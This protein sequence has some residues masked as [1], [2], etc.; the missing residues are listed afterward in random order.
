[1][2]I[3]V[4]YVGGDKYSSFF[5]WKVSLADELRGSCIRAVPVRLGTRVLPLMMHCL[6][7]IEMKR[8]MIFLS[9]GTSYVVNIGKQGLYQPKKCLQ[10]LDKKTVWRI[11][12]VYPGSRIL[13]FTHPGSRISDP[14]T[15]TGKRIRIS[16]TASPHTLPPP[17]DNHR[18]KCCT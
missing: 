10:F 11:R 1:M 3:K 14:K 13:I 16:N 5:P 7:E 18:R 8:S 2:R 6:S 9:I 17:Q 12:D 15:G 4:I